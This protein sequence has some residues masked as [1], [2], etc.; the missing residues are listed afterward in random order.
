MFK[1]FFKSILKKVP[2]NVRLRHDLPSTGVKDIIRQTFV[3]IGI[4]K[5]GDSIGKCYTE[6]TRRVVVYL[7]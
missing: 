6:T 4:N 5:G 2:S 3:F 1:R 7:R